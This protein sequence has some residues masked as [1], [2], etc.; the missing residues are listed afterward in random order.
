[1]YIPPDSCRFVDILSPSLILMEPVNVRLGHKITFVGPLDCHF[2]RA[3]V[4]LQL[5]RSHHKMH[6]WTRPW[7]PVA[8]TTSAQ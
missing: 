3:A 2:G 5:S 7:N 8:V 6:P 1:M 4:E